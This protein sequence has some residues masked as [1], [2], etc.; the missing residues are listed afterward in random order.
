M[1]FGFGVGDIILVS[2]ISY[3]L[4]T[5]ITE[6]RRN[7]GRDL[8]ELQDVL[9][10]LR[11]ALDHLSQ[12]ANDILATTSGNNHAGVDMR[13]QL[14]SMINSCGATLQ[15]LD[16]VTQKYRVGV[17]P[18][19]NNP[20]NGPGQ[21]RSFERFKQNL[22]INWI[23]IRWD[24]ERGSLQE[25]RTKLQS[26]TDIINIVLSTFVWYIYMLY[27]YSFYKLTIF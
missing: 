10:G 4:Y 8:K 7:S 20:G 24:I 3:S 23:K 15:D 27:S 14:N 18:T 2:Q 1:S 22:Q 5:S 16:S 11:C 26:H 19:H 25:Y 12:V 21:K 6:G 13:E 17:K 9:F